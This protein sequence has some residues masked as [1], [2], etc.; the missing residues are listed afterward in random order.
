M[1]TRR[2]SREKMNSRRTSRDQRD[3]PSLASTMRKFSRSVESMDETILIPTRL[4][5][6][7]DSPAAA[8]QQNQGEMADLYNLYSMLKSVKAEL[9]TMPAQMQGN[10]QLAR[11]LL[12][13]ENSVVSETSC[14]DASSDVSSDCESETGSEDMTHDA[15]KRFRYHLRGLFDVLNSMSETADH[16]TD[17]YQ[18]DVGVYHHTNSLL[19]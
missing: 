12:T 3:M 4:L 17:K 5:G 15:Q 8:P 1:G 19:F 11:K 14:S 2:F 10:R 13:R 7:N 18:A 6:L 9:S 16:I